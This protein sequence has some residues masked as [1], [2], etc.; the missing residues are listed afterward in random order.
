[1]RLAM[2]RPKRTMGHRNTAELA[3]QNKQRK[4]EGGRDGEKKRG[5]EGGQR[6]TNI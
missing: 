4:N 6:E 1:M 2:R 3:Q 5:R